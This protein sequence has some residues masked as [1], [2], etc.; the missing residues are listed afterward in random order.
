S[1]ERLTREPLARLWPL[2]PREPFVG[3]LLPA[4]ERRA[5]DLAHALGERIRLRRHVDAALP[6]IRNQAQIRRD[7][8]V[9]RRAQ[10]YDMKCCA[11]HERVGQHLLNVANVIVIDDGTHMDVAGRTKATGDAK[12]VEDLLRT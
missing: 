1:P 9:R 10:V 8:L 3:A 12:F 4:I 7:E 11:A 5:F 6:R 2:D